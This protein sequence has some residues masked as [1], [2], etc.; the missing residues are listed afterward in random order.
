MPQ[1][2]KKPCAKPGCRALTR[3]RYCEKHAKGGAGSQYERQRGSANQRGYTYRWQK[4][5][6]AYLADNPLCVECLANDIYEAA[7]Q[8]DHIKPHRGDP[9]LFWDQSNWQGLCDTHHSRK[10]RR[11]E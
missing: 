9:E 7:T 3:G 2:S 1:G 11:G 8:V 5:S 6:K 10:T 4:A